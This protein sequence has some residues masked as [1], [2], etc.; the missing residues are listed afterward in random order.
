MGRREPRHYGCGTLLLL[1]TV[2]YVGWSLYTG[3]PKPNRPVPATTAPVKPDRRFPAVGEVAVLLTKGRHGTFLA[4]NDGGWDEMLGAEDAKD[5]DY[6]LELMEI[7]KVF[8]VANGTRGRVIQSGFISMRLR[9]LEGESA[10][11][12]GWTQAENVHS[13]P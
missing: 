8:Y 13:L 10:G 12:E 1:G 7:G 5:P 3:E 6:M 4:V 2:A 11:L 9:I